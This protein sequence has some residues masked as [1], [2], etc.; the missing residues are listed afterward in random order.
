MNTMNKNILIIVLLI[1]GP[2][3][4]QAQTKK[5]INLKIG[6]GVFFT[7][8]DEIALYPGIII[9][10]CIGKKFRIEP[11][12]FYRNDDIRNAG[13]DIKVN[14]H[15]IGIGVFR[16]NY[17]DLIS[18]CYGIRIGYENEYYKNDYENVY[19]SYKSLKKVIKYSPL[20]GCEYNFHPHCSLGCETS[21]SYIKGEEDNTQKYMFDNNRKTFHSNNDYHKN[22]LDFRILFRIYF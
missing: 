4:V 20:V 12:V 17:I 9:P 3:S 5:D 19:G 1:F 11:E 7:S 14:K 10:I 18:I 2:I 16:S 8:Q 13:D 6:Y 22:Q 15:G 21:F